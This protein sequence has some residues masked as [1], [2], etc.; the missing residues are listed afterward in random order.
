MSEISLGN[1]INA[2]RGMTA[3]S[4]IFALFITDLMLSLCVKSSSLNFFRVCLKLYI[5]L[6]KM[7][8]LPGDFVLQIPDRGSAPGARWGTPIPQTPAPLQESLPPQLWQ[9]G[10]A[11]GNYG[12]VTPFL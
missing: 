1:R 2:F 9:P 5:Y 8:R 4:C 7:L 12:T 10:A 11:T 6:G 3:N